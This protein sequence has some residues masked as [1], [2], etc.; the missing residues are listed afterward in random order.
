MAE[1]YCGSGKNYENCC[2]PVIKGQKIAETAE[3]LMA[4]VKG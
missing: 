4:A 1:C 3:E 2:E